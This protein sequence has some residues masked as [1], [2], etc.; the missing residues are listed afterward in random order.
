MFA[1]S[2]GLLPVAKI[3]VHVVT[4]VE[5]RKMMVPTTFTVCTHRNG[6]FIGT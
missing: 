6:S 4:V 1:I 2:R 5:A 3:E